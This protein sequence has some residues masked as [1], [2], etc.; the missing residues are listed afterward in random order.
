MTGACPGDSET[1]PVT[2][3]SQILSMGLYTWSQNGPA[4]ALNDVGGVVETH[5]PN[6]YAVYAGSSAGS[7]RAINRGNVRTHTT[8]ATE[9]EL[10]G[11]RGAFGIFAWSE[12]ANAMAE[13]DATGQVT[14]K[15]PWAFG[16]LAQTNND[17]A[18]TRARAEA[19]NKGTISTEGRSALGVMATAG[20]GGSRDNPNI[21][22]ALN[23]AGARIVTT[24]DGADGLVAAI[25]VVNDEGRSFGTARAENKGTIA[26][27]GRGVN[28]YLSSGVYAG[29]FNFTGDAIVDAGAATVINSGD[30]TVTGAG[31]PGL[32]ALTYGSG[33]A[34][35]EMTGGT[36]VA[37]AADDPA[38]ADAD[39]SGIGIYASTGTEGMARVTVS[40][41]TVRAPMAARLEGGTTRLTLGDGAFLEGDVSFGAGADTL[42]TAGYIGGDVSFGAGEDTLLF[43]V[44]D[45]I[46]SVEGTITGLEDMIKRGAGTARVHD[47]TF[48]GSTLVVEQGN[49]EVR[50]H[51]NLGAEGAV[52]VRDAGRLTVLIGDIAADP[53]DHGRFTAGGGINL[54]GDDPAIFAS[55]DPT[56]DRGKK[57][58]VAQ[59][60]RTSGL[61]VALGGTRIREIDAEGDVV[62][63]RTGEGENVGTVGG[64]DPETGGTTITLDEGKDLSTADPAREE[65]REEQTTEREDP[66]TAA[67]TKDDDKKTALAIGGGVFSA[68]ALIEFFDLFDV[69]FG[70]AAPA[71]DGFA[72]WAPAPARA[73]EAGTGIVWWGQAMTGETPVPASAAGTLHGLRM[74]ATARLGDGFHLGLSGTPRMAGDIDGSALAGHRYA[75]RGGWESDALFANVD[76]AQGDYLAQTTF[77]N[78]DGLGRLSGAFGLRHERTRAEMG[79]RLELAGLRL[80]PSFQLFAGSLDR[81]AYTATSAALRSEIPALSQ[82]YDGWKARVSLAPED[83]LEAGA[84][85]WRPELNLATARIET[86]GPEGLRVRQADRAGVL[87]FTTP[88][89]AESL[90]RTMHAAG[91]AVSLAR[92]GDWTLRG[93]Y[94]ALVADG[95]PIHAAAARFRLRF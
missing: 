12:T 73:G 80:D 65:D 92:A 54:R 5:G 93:G 44:R 52:T 1:A 35:V 39:E 14:T 81:A 90:P 59:V 22:T 74:G 17:G 6:A 75:L 46:A 27:S 42:E 47:A 34:T 8:T 95:E 57:A 23:E 43:D 24:G 55:Y 13:N 85:R 63:L 40:G 15:G 25:N 32:R 71:A 88:A 60:L 51:L 48:T 36:V 9:G 28:L 64:P 72:A 84:L 61:T 89:V 26:T 67:A 33:T 78:L 79:A 50:G 7:V 62:P 2:V 37:S 10:P 11:H 77:A 70:D 86:D 58:A 19:V 4:Y 68:L 49:L 76:V 31:V 94:M 45:G 66:A 30:V 53:T 3:T 82:R 87:H 69:M 41:G 21:V 56:L 91:A 38:T 83:W 29:F 16:V 20:G 18:L